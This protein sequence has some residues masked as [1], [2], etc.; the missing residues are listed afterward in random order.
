MPDG[1]EAFPR[2]DWFPFDEKLSYA[3]GGWNY[4]RG[5]VESI[6]CHYR[7]WRDNWKEL[8]E[9]APIRK[10]TLTS[11]PELGTEWPVFS[12]N[13][14]MSFEV[15]GQIIQIPHRPYPEYAPGSTRN[16]YKT[17]LELRWP[18]IEFETTWNSLATTVNLPNE[19]LQFASGASEAP[20]RDITYE[21]V[22]NLFLYGTLGVP[23]PLGLIR[24]GS[25]P[26]MS[27]V[28]LP[29]ANLEPAHSITSVGKMTASVRKRKNRK[30]RRSGN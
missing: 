26:K 17:V 29:A 15:E 13:D 2:R 9:S 22:R 1:E 5:F 30:A 8:L 14:P 11:Q 25:L 6:R 12:H 23:P 7:N 18:G 20:L 21:L 3:H 10:V 4:H 19:L 27:F 28:Q 24:M 16:W